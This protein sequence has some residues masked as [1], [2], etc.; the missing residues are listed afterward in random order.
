[1]TRVMSTG[2]HHRR[3]LERYSSTAL[4]WGNYLPAC[5][6]HTEPAS[7]HPALLQNLP[8]KSSPH[9]QLHRPAR[10]RPINGQGTQTSDTLECQNPEAR[11]TRA[12]AALVLACACA[13]CRTCVRVHAPEQH[14]L[15]IRALLPLCSRPPQHT[16]HPRQG[17]PYAALH[18]H[19]H[20]CL[21]A[22]P[23]GPPC[24]LRTPLLRSEQP[25]CVAIRDARVL[26]WPPLHNNS[27][28]L[29]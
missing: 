12:P 7:C 8:S 19:A 6:M 9:G 25:R 29:K 17:T 3:S 5:S 16:T 15:A 14:R 28:L 21:R 27:F 10:I 11:A 26:P 2:A 18:C 22:G 4:S 1:M 13:K 24:R 23:A 20:L